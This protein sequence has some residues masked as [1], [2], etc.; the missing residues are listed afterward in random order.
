MAATRPM[1]TALHW[2]PRLL[3]A[4]AILVADFAIAPT[5]ASGQ[6]REETRGTGILR[7]LFMR[8]EPVE[9]VEQQAQ[10]RVIRRQR[11]AK[12]PQARRKKA[13]TVVVAPK[14]ERQVAQKLDTARTVLV[15][16]DFLG[17]G[18]A[19]GL[20]VAFEEQPEIRVVD[21]TNGSSGFVRDDYYD[22][23]GEIE[24]ILEEEKP[25]A[26]VVMI[27]S[28][29]RQQIGTEDVLSPEWTREYESRIEEFT[30][31]IKERNIPLVWVGMPAFK[32]STM[33][34]GMLAFNDIYRRAAEATPGGVFVD[35]WDG[36]V[37]ENG[38]FTISGP[39]INGQPVQLRSSDG[40]NLT[41]D[42][43]RKVAFYVEKPLERILGNT[44]MPPVA[45]EVFGPPMPQGLGTQSA[46]TLQVDRTMPVSLDDPALDGG[47]ELLGGTVMQPAGDATLAT[48]DLGDA[49]STPPPGRADNFRLRQDAQPTAATPQG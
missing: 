34:S 23:P 1:Q 20:E 10:R 30:A 4:V 22:W 24:G 40:I 33:T 28:N 14:P 36:F 11:Q 49:A 17:G 46:A 38:N 31:S 27:G 16:G 45:A 43:R 21:R 35:I 26:V 6:E 25:A 29:D 2:L 9:R 48:P 7:G 44:E 39:D 12:R 37:D 13:R 42:G 5:I 15:V 3:I 18:L 8:R 19:E 47:M 32:S 41:S